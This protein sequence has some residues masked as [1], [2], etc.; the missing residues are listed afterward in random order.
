MNRV[1]SVAEMDPRRPHAAAAVEA[2]PEVTLPDG[3]TVY[4]VNKSEAKLI[5]RTVPA[6]FRH[7]IDIKEGHPVLDV[8][9]NIGLFTR[10][11]HSRCQ[12]RVTVHAFEPIPAISHV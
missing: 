3:S 1:N 8:G 2:C 10:A 9:A 5:F 4:C 11:A 6:Y 7:G 12:G